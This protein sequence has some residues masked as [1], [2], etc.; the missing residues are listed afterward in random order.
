MCNQ[1]ACA[2]TVR[3]VI[4][5]AWVFV[6][7]AICACYTVCPA[8]L[9]RML[10]L[11]GEAMATTMAGTLTVGATDIGSGGSS[12]DMLRSSFAIL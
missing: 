5:I 2:K 10:P 8:L 11:D 1:V 3:A 12:F 7:A 9:G 6:C 4:A